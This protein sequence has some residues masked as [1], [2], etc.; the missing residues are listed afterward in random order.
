MS[1]NILLKRAESAARENQ[2]RGKLKLE[3]ILT[4]LY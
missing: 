3:D 4:P 2:T 1:E